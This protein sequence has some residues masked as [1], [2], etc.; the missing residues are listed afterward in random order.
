MG[1]GSTPTGK[2]LLSGLKQLAEFLVLEITGRSL[3]TNRK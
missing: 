2:T 3:I 1:L